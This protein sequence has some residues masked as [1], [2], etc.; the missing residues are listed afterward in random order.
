[1][2]PNELLFWLSARRCGS[3]VQFRAAVDELGLDNGGD[4]AVQSEGYPLYRRLRFNLQS[5]GHVEFNANGCENGWRVALPVLAL[6]SHD[7]HT[8]GVLCGARLPQL[9]SC[10]LA[11]AAPFNC[12]IRAFPEC[13]DAILVSA[14]DPS[15]LFG[16]AQTIGVRCQPDAPVTLLARLPRVT[17]AAWS[18]PVE[19][20]FGR[21]WIVHR[22]VVERR[23]CRWTDSSVEEARRASTGLFRFTRFSRPDH[24]VR[25]A[26]RTFRISGQVGKYR[27]L[28][29]KRRNILRFD[30]QTRCLTVPAICR[31]PMLVER[32]LVIC[33][34]KPPRYNQ[35]TGTLTYFD[36]NDGTAGFAADILC[37][38]FL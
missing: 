18:A 9:I 5:L 15:P 10:F 30:R 23:S 4:E 19:L 7:G 28:L 24:F 8:T 31:L 6:N 36:V 32:A 33:S 14:S 11:N 3:W 27:I 22:F 25:S 21:D 1:M 20:P 34:G 16:L 37:Q 12:Q 38:T 2:T 26:G 29:E 13:P 35:Q 17:D